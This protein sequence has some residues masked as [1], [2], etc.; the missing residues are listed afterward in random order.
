MLGRI[1]H[2]FELLCPARESYVVERTV[3]TLLITWGSIALELFLLIK[4]QP[5]MSQTMIAVLCAMVIHTECIEVCVRSLELK[6]LLQL[7]Q[8]I[9]SVR[10]HYHVSRMID[11]AIF[12]AM[13]EAPYEIRVHAMKFYEIITSEQCQ[14]LADQ[15][16]VAMHH[17]FL[18]LFLS[19]CVT[20]IEYGDRIV[21][22]QSLFLMNLTNL[23]V[24]IQLEILRLKQQ[25]YLYSGLTFVIVAPI[26]VM[27]LIEQWAMW[28]LPELQSFYMGEI[29]YIVMLFIVIHTILIYRVVHA[30]KGG[31]FVIRNEYIVLNDVLKLS[32][33]QRVLNNYCAGRSEMV[34]QLK[35]RID[36]SGEQ[37]DIQCFL[38]LKFLYAGVVL[39]CSI[40][41]RMIRC[42]S[43]GG[44]YHWY[45]LLGAIAMAVV[46]FYIPNIKLR[47]QEKIVDME[48]EDEII[49][50]QSIILMLMYLERVTILE[51][52]E[53]IED[54]SR[55]FRAQVQSCINNYNAS[56][57][58]ALE[59]LRDSTEFIPLKRMV[60]QFIMSDEIGIESAFDEVAAER[61][62]F[63]NKRKQENENNLN[64]RFEIAQFISYIP[65]ILVIGGYLIFP[66]LI[67]CYRQL[68]EYQELM[69]TIL[70]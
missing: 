8:F 20:V 49:R 29:G 16:H 54:F 11:E 51:I 57:L 24:E 40:T 35:S 15:Y 47:F 27:K 26:T 58:Q 13:D 66:F 70:Y 33:I 3:K 2:R 36:R 9:T 62:H 17:N 52:L 43:N 18:N 53:Q 25:T 23:K 7:E 67:E 56:D 10:H 38:F 21:R 60:D 12:D 5:S 31:S 28:N 55:I 1:R 6:I 59:G 44:R 45:E 32:F 65:A 30:L 64:R 39:I 4:M 37:V 34:K 46:C 68:Q 69:R 41:I 22:D 42:F 14:E 61:H 50:F 19:L 48:K 63:Q